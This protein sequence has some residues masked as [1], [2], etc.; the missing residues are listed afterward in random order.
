MQALKRIGVIFAWIIG[1]LLLI[2]VGGFLLNAAGKTVASAVGGLAFICWLASL[3]VWRNNIFSG[4]SFFTMA[5]AGFA[6]WLTEN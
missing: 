3:F 6:I 5:G 1:A 2:F 4:V